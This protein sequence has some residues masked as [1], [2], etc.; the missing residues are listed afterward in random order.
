MTFV[1]DFVGLREVDVVDVRSDENC[2]SN[3]CGICVEK[4]AHWEAMF[5]W[6]ATC[7]CSERTLTKTGKLKHVGKIPLKNICK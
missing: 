5:L 1:V 4:V 2:G 6:Y 7:T 3:G